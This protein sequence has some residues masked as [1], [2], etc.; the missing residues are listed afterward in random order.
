MFDVQGI[1][2]CDQQGGKQAGK[3]QH[4]W[5]NGAEIIP[6]LINN[7]V[8]AVRDKNLSGGK[9][10]F[11][12]FHQVSFNHFL[13]QSDHIRKSFFMRNAM[14]DNYRLGNT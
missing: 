3:Q 8:H 1:I 7:C 4:P 10:R 11:H 14:T 5:V 2:Q 13:C 9:T 12:F 6:E